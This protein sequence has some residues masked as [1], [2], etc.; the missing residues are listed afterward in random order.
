MKSRTFLKALGPGLLWAG[1][2]IGVSH[3]V[4]STRAGAGFGFELVWL[5]L[6]ANIFKYPFFEFGPR[7]AAATGESLIH[8]YKRMGNFAVILYA[9]ITISTMFILMSAVTAVTA[10][11]FENIFA[12][13][14]S[15]FQWS[16][17]ILLVAAGIIAFRKYSTIDRLIKFII[18]ILAVTALVALFAAL[19]K[20]FHPDPQYSNHFSWTTDIA[21]VLALVGWM[22]S[23]I[24]ISVWHSV[25]TTA[26]TK[27]SGYKPKLKESL[28]DFNIGYIGTVIL[29]LVFL[30]LGALVM[31]GTPQEFS[32]KGAAFAG[33]LIHLFTENLGAGA[34]YIIAPAALAAMVSTTLTCLDAYPR[35]LE[36]TTTLLFKRI[37]KEKYSSKLHFFWLF[38]VTGGTIT[39]FAYLMSSMADMVDF[40]TTVSFLVAPVLGFLNLKAVTGKNV[41]DA[42]KPKPW[43]LV[44]SWLGLFFLTALSI[45]FIYVRFL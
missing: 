21:F 32:P 37:D 39:I 2:A 6:L 12:F 27:E 28:L 41:P 19:S 33:E 15:N 31:Y 4:Q 24:D 25:W 5:L 26:K 1:A 45:Y 30:T 14:W 18:I 20:G 34:Y 23:A 10:G 29:S 38:I 3:L 43:L 8:G 42:A 35:V 22:P 36:P 40:A 16:V 11:L 44:L 13:G 17:L 9:V 7:Y